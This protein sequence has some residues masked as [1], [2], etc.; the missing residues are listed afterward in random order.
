MQSIITDLGVGGGG[1]R[2]PETAVLSLK[3]L[4]TYTAS[5]AHIPGTNWVFI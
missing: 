4:P 1:R 2:V 5:D 3:A